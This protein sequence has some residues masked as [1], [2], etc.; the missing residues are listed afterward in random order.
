MQGFL[1]KLIPYTVRIP[2]VAGKLW[3][4]AKKK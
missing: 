4:E 1:Q 2:G 3:N